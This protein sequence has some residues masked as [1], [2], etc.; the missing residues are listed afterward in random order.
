MNRKGQN[1]DLPKTWFS[2]ILCQFLV[3]HESMKY[4]Q[5]QRSQ[6]ITDPTSISVKTVS[7]LWSINIIYMILAIIQ[8][9]KLRFFCRHFDPK[10]LYVRTDVQIPPVFYR[11][12]SPFGAKAQ[13]A[14]ARLSLSTLDLKSQ[15]KIN[16]EIIPYEANLL[17]LSA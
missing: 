14:D 11:T 2:V 5:T 10:T 4:R 15:M 6:K 8:A 12:L 16:F 3:K 1:P 7:N 17:L 9:K 13:K